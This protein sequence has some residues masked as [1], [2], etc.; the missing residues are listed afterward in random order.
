MTIVPRTLFAASAA[1][2]MLA[3][4]PASA[5]AFEP[6][7]AMRGIPDSSTCPNAQCRFTFPPVPDDVRLLV[8]SVSAQVAPKA[9]LSW[10]A[11]E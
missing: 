8:S 3:A 6:F 2:V 7:Q 1:A 5:W 11:A 10:R 4:S 9:V